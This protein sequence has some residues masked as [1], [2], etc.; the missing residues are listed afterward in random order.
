M[1]FSLVIPMYCESDIILQTLWSLTAFLT[2]YA[3]DEY[4]LIFCDDGST[5]HTAEL[6]QTELDAHPDLYANVR[7]LAYEKN[8]GK[9]YAVR[10]AMLQA[11][12][13]FVLF[14]DCDL[15]YGC[16]VLDEFFT[17]YAQNSKSCDAVIGSR[18]LHEEGLLGYSKKRRLMSRAYISTVQC[19]TRTKLHDTQTGIKGFSR[20]LVQE[21][22][23][24]CR[25][26]RFAFDL[27]ILLF[28]ERLGYRVQE[29]PVKILQNRDK[30]SKIRPIRDTFT[31]LRDVLRIRR[32]VKKTIKKRVT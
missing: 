31:M 28:A 3:Q 11:Q 27:E 25:T 26:D 14:T 4:E 12:G 23:P 15:A 30:A 21:V 16:E 8:R 10:Y 1:R 17:Y 20:A 29:Y 22:F 19:L 13:D 9:G 2:R 24:L 32:H 18:A 5:D 7:L 6:L